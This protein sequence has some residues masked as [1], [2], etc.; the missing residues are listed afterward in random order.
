METIRE[1]A[2]LNQILEMFGGNGLDLEGGG[3]GIGNLVKD[4]DVAQSSYTDLFSK[5]MIENGIIH[6][7]DCIAR[8]IALN[9]DG[10]M[11]IEI[12]REGD[13]FLDPSS[14]RINADFCIKKLV[15]NAGAPVALNA[16]DAGKMCP[17]NL[18][19]KAMFENIDV[20]INQ[21]KVSLVSTPAYPIKCFIE[22]VCSYGNDAAEGHLLASYYY[23]DKGKWKE[24]LENNRAAR[25]ERHQFIAESSNVEMCDTV[26]TEI[27]TLNR[28]L[29]PGLD[30]QFMFYLNSPSLYLQ[31]KPPVADGNG[32]IPVADTFVVEFKDFYLSYDRV[33][34]EPSLFNSIESK[35]SRNE[36]AI[37]PITRSIVKT[38]NVPAQQL[39]ILWQNLYSGQLPETI[40][41]AMLD[42]EAKNGNLHKN[43]F[44]FQD[45]NMSSIQLRVNSRAIP[46]MP[47]KLDCLNKRAYRAYR[48]FCD[49]IGIENSNLPCLVTYE[50]FCEGSTLIPFDLTPDKA[51]TQ[52]N[53]EKQTGNIEL[54]IKFREALEQGITVFALCVFNDKFLITG[55]RMN[56]E[57]I[58]NPNL[59]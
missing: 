33:A 9:N 2:D 10:P 26:H 30:I 43:Y 20:Y 21:T 50:D 32:R 46:S 8:P 54:D 55:P 17:V 49:N 19:T 1:E 24:N 6:R 28:L 39:D 23:K 59:I 38:K 58:L 44:N 41:I 47:L 48:H 52:H 37:F 56:R 11:Q 27:T 40:I 53:H 14:I 7:R 3:T 22:T 4:F 34:L 25:Q 15:K 35:L 12:P 57:V 13:Y 45:F 16:D 29:P 5:E 18:F 42:T 31:S 51:A 36:K